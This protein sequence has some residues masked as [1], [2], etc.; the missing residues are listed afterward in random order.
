M[1]ERAQGWWGA[2]NGLG[3][4]HGEIPAASAGMTEFIV[5]GGGEVRGFLPAQE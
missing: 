3:A 5:R 1:T 2:G 4:Q